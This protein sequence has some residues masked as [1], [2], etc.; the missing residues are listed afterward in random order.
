MAAAR[1]G[2]D[3]AGEAKKARAAISFA[4]LV[5]LFLAHQQKRI[6]SKTYRELGRHLENHAKSLHGK[7]ADAVGQ[8]DIVG[9]LQA[10]TERGPILANRV[11]SSIS[12][13][14]SWGMKAGLVTSNPVAATFKPAEERA[15]DR[16]SSDHE[17]GLIWR[18]TGAS[19]DHDRIVRLLML[20]G[21]R[22]E[23]VA[24][25]RWSE[26]TRRDDGTAVWVL[27]A[28]R[29]KNRRALELI[30]PSM[31]VGLLPMPRE[32]DGS[33]RDLLFGEGRGPF[34]GWSQC[35]ARLDK[36]ITEANGG[37][38]IAPWVLHDLRRTFVTR[39]NDLGVEPHI[40]EALVNHVSGQA[41]AGVAGVYNRSAYSV[42]KAAAL[43]TWSKHIAR[44]AGIDNDPLFCGGQ[45][46]DGSAALAEVVQ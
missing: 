45:T 9:L 40:I 28:E 6:R 20:T 3:P 12:A 26:I 21:A 38:P 36:R 5:E 22:R 23:E 33:V 16:V 2:G 1:L 31:I 8:R 37:R 10:V 18:C 30:L 44:I 39:L 46:H 25:I 27:P 14:Y 34:S 32:R 43:K 15:R 35:K 13:A 19:T 4:G 17:L 29:S 41:T 7:R 11:R 24:G 42:Q